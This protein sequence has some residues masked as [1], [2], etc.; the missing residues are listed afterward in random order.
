MF[1]THNE[2]DDD[3]R[4]DDSDGQEKENGCADRLVILVIES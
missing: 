3:G 2:D 4:S 1:F